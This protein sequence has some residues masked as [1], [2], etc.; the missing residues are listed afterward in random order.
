MTLILDAGAFF[1]LE[2]DDR[3]MWRRLKAAQL[4]G[5][6]P[7]THGGVVAQIW[8]DGFG[9]QVLLARAL[10]GVDVAGLD[11]VLG[12]RAG[13]LL[14]RTAG[15]DAIDAAVVGLASDDDHIITSD[16]DDIQRLVGAAGIHVDVI[17]V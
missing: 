12:R 15:H 11:D 1:A 14:A 10:A 6:P 3:A 5:T 8:R 16:A 13:M 7:L 17:P 4:S 9:R 2:R